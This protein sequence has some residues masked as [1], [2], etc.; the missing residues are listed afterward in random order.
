[1]WYLTV[2]YMNISTR[3]MFYSGRHNTIIQ[4]NTAHVFIQGITITKGA[5]QN[6]DTC[7]CCYC[8]YTPGE[9]CHTS[10]THHMYLFSSNAQYELINTLQNFLFFTLTILNEQYKL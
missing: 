10:Q 3:N 6:I 8:C 7:N 2:V 1:M 4:Q 9:K 5:A